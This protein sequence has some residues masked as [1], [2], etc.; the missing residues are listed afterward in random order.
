M[1]GILSI[2]WNDHPFII[3]QRLR[4]CYIS[5][6]YAEPTG[7]SLQELKDLL[8]DAPASQLDLEGL[9]LLIVD[10]ASIARREKSA[11]ALADLVDCIDEDLLAQGLRMA[12]EGKEE[13]QIRNALETRMP[14]LLKS[15]ETRYRLVIEGIMLIQGG[16]R[17]E[18]VVEKLRG[19]YVNQ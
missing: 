16:C 2:R 14:G 15:H 17:P 6:E 11:A 7:A 13:G 5:T 1:E 8:G 19:L 3:N 10:M 12:V 9:R 18:E 4:N